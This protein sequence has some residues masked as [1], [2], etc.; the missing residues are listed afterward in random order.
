MVIFAGLGG[1][2]QQISTV[3]RTIGSLNSAVKVAVAA[4]HNPRVVVST[5]LLNNNVVA[6]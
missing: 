6:P 2:S 5:H 1:G 3:L 4:R